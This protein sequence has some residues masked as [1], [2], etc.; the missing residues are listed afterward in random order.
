MYIT[1]APFLLLGEFLFQALPLI[2]IGILFFSIA[3]AFQLITLPIEFNAS[4]RTKK[5]ILAE[6]MIHES[7]AKSINKVLGAAA[8]TYVA[9]ALVSVL[10][11]IK[12]IMIFFQGSEEECKDTKRFPIQEVDLL[13]HR[14]K[15]ISW[16]YLI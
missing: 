5:L 2:G 14:T 1:V 6:G 16:R 12:Y 13:V 4:S 15:G 8:L 3:V 11:L 9:G 10:E 7:D